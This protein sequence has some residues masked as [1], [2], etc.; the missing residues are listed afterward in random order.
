MDSTL[1]KSGAGMTSQMMLMAMLNREITFNQIISMILFNQLIYIIPSFIVF[2]KKYGYIFVEKMKNK[3]MKGKR[4]KNFVE[5]EKNIKSEIIYNKH[6]DCTIVN[7]INNYIT[8]LNESKNLT[9]YQDYYVTNKEE[10]QIAPDIYCKVYVKDILDTNEEEKKSIDYR[11]IVYSYKYELEYLRDFINTLNEKYIY[12]LNNKLGNKK[13]YFDEI[14]MNVPKGPSGEIRHEMMPRNLSF[15]MTEFNTNKSLHNVF[16]KHLE[17]VK[18]R[19]KLFQ[20]DKKWYEDKGIP[21]TLGIL[22]HGPPGT[23]KTSLIKAIAKYCRRHIFN[24]KLSKYSTKTQLRNLFFEK[25][26][27]VVNENGRN[28]TY[29][30]PL[31]ERIYLIEDI[32]CLTDIVYE[33]S[34]NKNNMKEKYST[35]SELDNIYGSTLTRGMKNDISQFT[36][37][38]NNF[39]II[40]NNENK[41]IGTSIENSNNT[42]SDIKDNIKT[43][44]FLK[45]EDEMSDGLNLSFLLNLLDGILETPGRILIMTTN[46]PEKLDKALIRPGRIDL[47]I[48]V[49]FCD[50]HLIQEMFNHFFNQEKNNYDF[51][52]L[53]YVNKITP[54]EVIK[55]LLNNYNSIEMSYNEIKRHITTKS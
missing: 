53:N 32:D 15:I 8:N 25:K 54:A 20:N 28:V 5:Q 44:E 17:I 3:L 50:L 13:F 2:F 47:N 9:Y 38:Y 34:M 4:I 7:A 31:D 27:N 12:E 16:G 49:D 48:H 45:D 41:K 35:S 36:D 24:I 46:H 22:L 21:H 10:F 1:F 51:S 55:Y 52:K 6:K 39:S 43:E 33:R 11:I 14:S 40:Q 18:E 30:I 23:G 19:I 42:I 37:G 26:I 29:E